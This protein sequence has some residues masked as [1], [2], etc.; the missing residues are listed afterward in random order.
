VHKG[1]DERSI[2]EAE[3]GPEEAYHQAVEAAGKED[4]KP[5]D[6]AQDGEDEH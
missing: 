2:A 6:E 1:E 5:A 4:V 3:R